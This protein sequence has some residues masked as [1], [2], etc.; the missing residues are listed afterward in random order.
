MTYKVEEAIARIITRPTIALKKVFD[1]LILTKRI[2]K[3]GN[4][5]NI[6]ILLYFGSSQK[7]AKVNLNKA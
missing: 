7:L 5:P 6:K 4:T 3:V 2:N 1:H